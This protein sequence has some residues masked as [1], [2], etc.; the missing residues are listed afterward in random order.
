MNNMRT[1]NEQV[2]LATRIA[3]SAHTG[4]TDAAGQPYFAAHLDPIASLLTPYGWRAEA[5]GW[6]HDVIEDTDVDAAELVDRG[7]DLEVVA[8][9]QAVTRIPGEKYTDLIERAAATPLSA[10]VK[11]AD[12]AWNLAQ[13]PGLR[14]IDPAKADSLLWRYVK[15]RPVLVAGAGLTET[16]GTYMLN[17]AI[18]RHQGAQ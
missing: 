13:N 18:A 2:T 3:L 1:R 6:L 10:L 17:K 15:A 14:L 12:N 8:A 9:V 11:A 7:I 5:A 4:Q 16:E